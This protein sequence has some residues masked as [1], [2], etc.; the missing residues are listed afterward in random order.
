MILPSP[1]LL[2]RHA[3]RRCDKQFAF[4]YSHNAAG[5]PAPSVNRCAARRTPS[6]RFV[7]GAGVAAHR[8]LAARPRR[9]R[10][11]EQILE[12]QL[13]V[14]T[15]IPSGHRWRFSQISIFGING[16]YAHVKRASYCKA[17]AAALG[18]ADAFVVRIEAANALA[19]AVGA[20]SA[21]I[22]PVLSQPSFA[23]RAAPT[24]R[25]LATTELSVTAPE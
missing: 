25:R 1:V 6:L 17:D 14:E 4:F 9:G 10:V 18:F 2:R 19:R 13:F 7:S 20:A 5:R 12:K 3:R 23:A 24:K 11:L 8:S 22:P 16:C 21:A 15:A